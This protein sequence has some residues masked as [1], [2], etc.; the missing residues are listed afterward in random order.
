[1]KLKVETLLDQYK[2]DR[3]MY[4]IVTPIVIA[5]LIITAIVFVLITKIWWGGLIFLGTAAMIAVMYY[6][7]IRYFNKLIKE[8]EEKEAIKNAK[9]LE[10]KE[11]MDNK[12]S[13]D[14]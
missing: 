11:E 12:K 9:E 8:L 13:D 10:E 2:L 14:K 5:G 3:A 7:I 4:K 6:F 1:M